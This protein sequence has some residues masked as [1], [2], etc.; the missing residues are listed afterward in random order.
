MDL[1]GKYRQF[2]VLSNE[3]KRSLA[4]FRQ[5]N[6]GP[7]AKQTPFQS[8]LGSEKGP[9]K[10]VSCLFPGANRAENAASAPD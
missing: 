1:Y 9:I 10:A 5:G 8:C 7:E 6:S 2:S 4:E 3:M